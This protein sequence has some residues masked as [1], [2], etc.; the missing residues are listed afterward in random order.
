MLDADAH[1]AV[2]ELRIGCAKRVGGARRKPLFGPMTQAAAYRWL[3]VAALLSVI[4]CASPVLVP[5]G[6]D[7]TP[8]S[9]RDFPDDAPPRVVE[10]AKRVLR[11][12]YRKDLSILQTGSG[13]IAARP[14]DPHAVVA[15][16][17]EQWQFSAAPVPPRGTRASIAIGGL[18]TQM[19]PLRNDSAAQA[20][21]VAALSE[22]FWVR[23][24]YVLG[25]G[26]EWPS[27]RQAFEADARVSGQDYSDYCDLLA[28]AIDTA[29]APRLER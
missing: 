29:P 9:A 2:L 12:L 22:L 13:F 4:G 26:A 24:G 15:T 25:R 27:C 20:R 14:N 8:A 6:T 1:R 11:N 28:D 18:E 10:A 23:V 19:G 21:I 3:A 5:G 7:T 17:G 16:S